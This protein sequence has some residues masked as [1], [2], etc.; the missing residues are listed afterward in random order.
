MAT[1][2]IKGTT[3]IEEEAETPS[4]AEVVE[5]LAPTAKAFLLHSLNKLSHLSLHPQGDQKDLLAKSIGSKVIMP[6]IVIIEWILP[7]KA[8]IQQ[9]KL[10]AMA[11]ASN[12]QHTQNAETWLTDSSASDHI[13]ASSHNLNPQA[14]Y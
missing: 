7:I 4:E 12:L 1:M 2:P 13:T 8:R 9:P 11:S 3:T 10:A 14:P 5:L 6:L